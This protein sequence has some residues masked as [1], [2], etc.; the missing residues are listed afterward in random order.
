[1]KLATLS[2]LAAFSMGFAA[3][4]KREIAEN[5]ATHSVV[6]P[7]GRLKAVFSTDAG[8]VRWSLLRD[9]KALVKPSVMGFR[10]AAG[11]DCDKEAVKFSEMK[12]VGVRRSSADTLWA[13]SLY[14]RSKVR[15]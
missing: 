6:S 10:F 14:R 8:G 4:L 15:D 2:I 7:D 12:V 5:A 9:G 13:T 3:E 11:N 1:M